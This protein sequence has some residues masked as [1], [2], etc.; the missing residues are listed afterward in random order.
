M[1]ASTTRA[2]L[3]T[4]PSRLNERKNQD[5]QPKSYVDAV[6][7]EPVKV[8]DEIANGLNSPSSQNG[9]FGASEAQQ[10]NGGTTGIG[11]GPSVLRVTNTHNDEDATD[12]YEDRI[13][14]NDGTTKSVRSESNGDSTNRT[15]P[16]YHETRP[17]L[18]CQESKHE[19]SATVCTRQTALYN[20][21]FI[22]CLQG[23]DESLGSPPRQKY[24]ATWQR[25]N[26]AGSPAANGESTLV[27]EKFQDENNGVKLVSVKP[28]G[29]YENDQA[30]TDNERLK[31]DADNRTLVSGRQ[32]GKRWEISGIRFAPMNVPLQR[33]LQ[34]LVVLFHST[35]IALSVSAFF[36]LCAIPIFWP[37]LIIYMIYCMSS[38]AATS[39]RLN[40]RSNFLRSSSIWSL[41]ASYFPARLHRSEEL[42]PTR[43]YIFG[44][45]PHGI[46]SHGA[47]AAFTTEALGFSQ[48]FPGITNTLLTLDS[49]FRIPIYRD[50]ILAMGLGS[51]S[52]ESCENLLSK[53][54][55]NNGEC[56]VRMLLL[57]IADR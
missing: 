13:E 50:Y 40:H 23:L 57:T 20:A 53:G 43:K 56:G 38:N 49:N 55:K 24:K 17:G 35:C 10:A 54:G 42:P 5:L 26:G 34:T 45:H 3:N 18:E 1:A 44:Y 19:Y 6:R 41:F 27:F 9:S 16:K 21:P 4:E 30:R 29:N 11:K 47:F 33:R 46:I 2:P 48:L 37:L 15:K 7:K 36:F 25:S 14:N 32:A 51:V 22:N 12:G 52:R 8:A 28:A 31:R 39:G